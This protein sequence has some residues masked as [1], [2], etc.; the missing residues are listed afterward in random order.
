MLYIIFRFLFWLFFKTYL[1]F[2]VYGS[3]K[4]PKKGAFIFVSNHQSYL[5]PILLGCS[6]GRLLNYMARDTL[7]KKPVSRW[8]MRRVRSFP[9]KRG[10]GDAPALK[11]AL[12]ILKS[13]NPLVMFPEGTRVKDGNLKRGKPGVGFIVAKA[14]VPVIPA[15]VHGS[16]DA[17]ARG[18]RTLER[19]PV[20]VHIGDPIVFDN[21]NVVRGDKGAYQHISDEIMQHIEKLKVQ[22]P[23]GPVLRKGWFFRV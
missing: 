22:K 16:F 9:V 6:T 5:D 18:V 23:E 21:L 13:G 8:A 11:T 7:F 14:G 15:Y 10:Q 4:I 1:G 17:L 3:R 12:K 19:H 2:H 20:S